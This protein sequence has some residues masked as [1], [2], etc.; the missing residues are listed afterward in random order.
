MVRTVD[1]FAGTDVGVVAHRDCQRGAGDLVVAGVILPG[2][3]GVAGTWRGD[4]HLGVDR[5]LR[6]PVRPARRGVVPLGRVEP[7]RKR[8]QPTPVV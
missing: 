7:A 5:R 1:V 2:A 3:V 8:V 6:P 4:H